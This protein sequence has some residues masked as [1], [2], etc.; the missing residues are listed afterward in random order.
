M[1][2]DFHISDVLSV[3]QG[4][5]LSTRGMDGLYDILRYLAGE[6]VSTNQ[7]PRL[8]AEAQPCIIRL[9]PFLEGSEIKTAIADLDRLMQAEPDKSRMKEVVCDW[10]SR[11]QSGAYG[12]GCPQMLT[13][14]PM[15]M[16]EHERIDAESEAAEHFP[17]SSMLVVRR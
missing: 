4:R 10:A 13:L 7:I 1:S 5:L 17:P 2:Q 8:L 14:Q 15:S 16:D 9:H 3:T 11:L 6:P 12:L